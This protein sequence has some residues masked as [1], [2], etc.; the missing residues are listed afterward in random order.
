MTRER[1]RHHLTECVAHLRASGTR[2]TLDLV[3]EDLRLGA[4]CIGRITGA[5]DVED[6]LDVVFAGV[7]RAL[8]LSRMACDKRAQTSVSASEQGASHA[9]AAAVRMYF[10]V[11]SKTTTCARTAAATCTNKR[12]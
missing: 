6:L 5:V 10:P 12:A 1:H 11:F 3:S 7:V 2:S 8:L 4:A 9:T